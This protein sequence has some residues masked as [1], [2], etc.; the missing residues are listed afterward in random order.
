MLFVVCSERPKYA[1]M[2]SVVST[3]LRNMCNIYG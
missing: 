3:A 2:T 1:M